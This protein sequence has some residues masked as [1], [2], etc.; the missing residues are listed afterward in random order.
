MKVLGKTLGSS[1]PIQIKR[2]C[3]LLFCVSGIFLIQKSWADN[4]IS[5]RRNI[6]SEETRNPLGCY[7]KGYQ[8]DLKTL[9]LFPG[10]EGKQQT[11]YF[12][13]NPLQQTITLYQMLDS[14]DSARSIYLNH[15]IHPRQWAVLATSD[16][17]VRFIC[18]VPSAKSAYGKIVDCSK[19]VRVCEY[20]NVRYGLNN[21]GNYWIVNSNTRGGAIGEVIHYGIIPAP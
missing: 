21:R 20:T 11:M 2:I 16:K 17:Q 14:S 10:K 6:S 4:D 1:K 7:D 5:A 18:T 9:S 8:F 15:S 19:N 3:A 13:F 12:L